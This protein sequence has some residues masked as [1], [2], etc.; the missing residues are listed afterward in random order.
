M[1]VSKT[2]RYYGTLKCVTVYIGAP[3]FDLGPSYLMEPPLHPIPIRT[4]VIYA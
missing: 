2:R 1:F 4:H 3:L